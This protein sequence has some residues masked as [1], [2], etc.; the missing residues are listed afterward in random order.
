MNDMRLNLTIEHGNRNALIAGIDYRG[1]DRE[2]TRV[3]LKEANVVNP[4][5]LSK[6]TFSNVLKI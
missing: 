2:C 3:C 4:T 5:T 6:I 1:F